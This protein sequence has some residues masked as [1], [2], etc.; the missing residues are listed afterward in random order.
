MK[1]IFMILTLVLVCS[2]SFAVTPPKIVRDSFAKKFPNATKVIWGKENPKEWEAEFTLEGNK[3]SA[4]Y[5]NDGSWI[6]TEKVIKY[7]DLPKPVLLAISTHYPGWK[8][9][10]ADEIETPKNGKTYEVDLK[11]GKKKKE[12][13]YK[14]NGIVILE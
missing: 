1:K 6:E 13:N 14:A 12:V 7:R 2:Y 5:G 8:I 10:E 3:F 4:N 11:K 9:S